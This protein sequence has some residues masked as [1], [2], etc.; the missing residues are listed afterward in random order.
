VST[1]GGLQIEDLALNPI[2]QPAAS[3][4]RTS[5]S[6]IAEIARKLRD[7]SKWEVRKGDASQTGQIWASGTNKVA[8]LLFIVQ[9]SRCEVVGAG[10][11]F[12]VVRVIIVINQ[13]KAIVL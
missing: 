13:G 8:P 1:V 9:T 4:W 10:K 11:S 12:A 5:G 7:R 2:Q 3:V 6:S